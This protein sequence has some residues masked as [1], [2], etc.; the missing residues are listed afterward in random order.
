MLHDGREKSIIYNL[1]GSVDYFMFNN[2]YPR[3]HVNVSLEIG[4]LLKALC[5]VHPTSER[6]YVPF[7]AS[8]LDDFVPGEKV[9][10]VGKFLS[11]MKSVGEA[12]DWLKVAVEVFEGL[13][14][15]KRM[16]GKKYVGKSWNRWIGEKS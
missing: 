2:T 5:C 1:Q 16:V 10:Q 14:E 12:S 6:V 8:G 11:E 3:V 9:P 7:R 4:H 15:L 13:P